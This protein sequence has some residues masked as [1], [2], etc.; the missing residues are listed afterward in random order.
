MDTI[1]REKDAAKPA[2]KKLAA[3]IALINRQ[4]VIWIVVLLVYGESHPFD[5][6]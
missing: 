3:K 6:I 1:D 4:L 5:H 2:A